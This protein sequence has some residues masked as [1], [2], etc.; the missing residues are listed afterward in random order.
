[1]TVVRLAFGFFPPIILALALNDL[2]AEHFK[3]F[4]QTMSH[5]PYFT[6]SVV[7]AGM[8]LSFI[9]SDGVIT[10]LMRMLGSL[11]RGISMNPAAFTPIYVL[12]T[13]WK[14]FGFDSILYLSTLSSVDAEQYEAA[15]ID[16]AT[17]F[18]QTFSS[19]AS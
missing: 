5:M 13:I 15:R 10:K 12:A 8:V 2:R 17:R 18:Q 16:G 4:V 3:S 6:S 11:I 7:V 9:N 14:S 1:M 19:R